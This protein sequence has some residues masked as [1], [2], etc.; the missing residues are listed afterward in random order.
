VS[1]IGNTLKGIIAIA[2]ILGVATAGIGIYLYLSRLLVV[3]TTEQPVEKQPVMFT[4][5]PGQS[6]NEIAENLQSEGLIESPFV[7][8]VRLKLR[9]AETSLQSGRFQVEPGMDVDQLI[10]LLST[11]ASEVGV[12]FT[13]IEGVRL[14]E[15]AE[16]LAADGIVDGAAFMQMAGT[17]EG[18]AQFQ[19]DFLTA[20][21]RPGDKGLEGYLFPDT[22]EIK[23]S[24][25]DN[26][27]AVIDVMLKTME[28]KISPEMRQAIADRGLT[29]HQVLTVASIVQR[30]GVVQDELPRIS[31]VFWNRIER[32]MTL[33]AD[34]TTQYAVG[35]PG[36]WWP[37]LKLDPN[38]VD[39]AYNTYRIAGLP[40]GPICNP[41]LPA[42]AAAVYPLQNN[43]L[44]FV[45]KGDGSGAH[46]FAETLEEH[47]R[48]RIIEGNIE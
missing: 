38:S 9:G 10:T 23:Q 48:N 43:E 1:F 6:V 26:S 39:H 47:E 29:I 28:E 13:V 14:E 45:A 22:Y 37:I 3:P 33:G 19:D 42:I 46:V 21:G 4:I 18:S 24:E 41:G 12:R 32:D 16:K 25:G 34:P 17:P 8:T 40:P 5:E 20:S 35:K 30:E 31:A 36:E 44:Y 11:P 15:I 7:F 27:K 2:M